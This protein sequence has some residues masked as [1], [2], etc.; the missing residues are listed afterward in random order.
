MTTSSPHLD[1][2]RCYRA[3]AGRDPRFDGQFYTAVA[4][5]GIY[6][7]PSCPA[8]TPKA[9]NVSFHLT[10]AA[11]QAAGYRACRR[12][13]PDAVPGS[14]RWNLESDLAARAM[15]LI[16]DGV[17]DRAGVA[18]L[19]ER[20]G[21][22]PRQLTRVLTAELGAG[23]LA[24]ARA[25]RATTARILITSTA[26]PFSDIAF[27]AG[28]SSIR[29]F[30]DTIR[31]V[32]ART[33]SELRAQR[34]PDRAAATGELSLRLALRGPYATGWVRWFLG[35]HAVAGLEHAD[36]DRYTRV[37][38]LPGGNGIATV[39]LG[40]VPDGYVR[41]TLS[42]AT[43]SDLSTAVARL[44]HLLGLDADPTATDEALAGDPQLAPLVA[45]T[46]GIR[47]FGDVDPA[48]LLVRT[49]IGQQISIA[50]AATHEARLVATL[51]EEVDDPE[52]RVTHAFPTPAAIAE[53]GAAVLTGPRARVSAILGVATE[54]AAG[55]IDLHAGMT[56]AE[57]RAELLRLRGVGPWTADYVAMRM[58]A[59][60]DTLLTSDLVVAKGARLLDLD[61]T[62]N[63]WTPWGSYVSLHLWN[64]ALTADRRIAP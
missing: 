11:A 28:F 64:H 48:E 20:L 24:L 59:D 44:R 13:L 49:M 30:N 21:Y 55:R 39:D 61:V 7:R 3:I 25:H 32:F 33:P 5:T 47:L 38:R 17:V 10:A 42:L 8:T 31:E 2:D 26:M 14:P 45:G 6:C 22:S 56:R 62:S 41:A 34:N 60:P 1:F 63:R 4:T 15:R 18:G 58:L 53:E 37:L 19:A 52:G 57:A 46:P 54:L 51:G 35:A 16:A 50:A 36:G 23:P 43:M 12:C 29:Q 9:E 40:S 27:A